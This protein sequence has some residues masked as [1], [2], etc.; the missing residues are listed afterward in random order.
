MKFFL[1]QI[2]IYNHYSCDPVVT[3]FSA[4]LGSLN[5]TVDKNSA[6]MSP[7]YYME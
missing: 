2:D 7:L 5:V 6:T 1:A 4:I 3:D